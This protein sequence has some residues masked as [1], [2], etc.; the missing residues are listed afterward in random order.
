MNDFVHLHLHSQYSVLDG[1]IRLGD[2]MPR[3]KEHGMTSVAVTDHGNMFGAVDF[4]KK[5]QKYGI[6]PILGVEAYVAEGDRR[7]KTRS[8]FH[9]ILL[10]R[11][12]TGYANLRKLVSFAYLEGFY[13]HPRIDLG[14]LRQHS[15][16]L[17]G[18]SA[19]LGGQIA[20]T[21]LKGRPD[22]AR[23]L[24]RTY[25]DI[26]EPGCFFLEVQPNGIPE[27][28]VVNE[29]YRQIG[30]ELD[31]PLA[32]T[33]DCHYLDQKDAKAH[34]ILMCVQTGKTLDDPTRMRHDTD[35]FWLRPG[36]E[37]WRLMGSEFGDALE[38]TVRIAEMCNVKLDLGN[39]YLPAYRV[40]DDMTIDEFL[41]KKSQDGL[42]ERFNEFADVGKSVD[43]AEYQRRLDDELGVISKMGFA[44]YFL[45]VQDFINWAKDHDIPVGPGRGSGAGSL[46]AYCLRITD[47]DPLPY[48]LLFERFL[49]PERVSMPDF[50]VDFCMNRRDEVIKYV[51][52]KYGRTQVGQIATFGSLKA[53]GVIKDVGRVLGMSFGETDKLSKLVPEVLNITLD[54]AMKQEPRLQEIYDSEP[55]IRELLDIARSLEGLNRSVGMHAAGVVIGDK[56]LWEYCPVFKGANEDLVTQFAKDEVEQAGLVKF[57]FLG[58]KTLTVIQTAVELINRGKKPEDRLDLNKLPLTDPGVYELISRGDTEGVFQLES[59]GFQELLKKLRPDKFEDIV[60]AVALYRPGPLNSGM[61]DDFIDRKHGRQKIVYPHDMLKGILQETYGVIVYQEQVMQIAQVLAGFT[62]GGADLLRRAMGKKKADVMAQQRAVF[63]EGAAKNDVPASQAGEIFDLMEKF[64]EYGFNKSHSAAYALI[65]Y[66]TAYLKAHH[67]VEFMAGL[68]TNDKDASDKVS[69]GIRNAR[70]IGIEVLAPS[71]NLSV[72]DFDVVDGK[73]LF[74]MAGIRGV[75]ENAVEAIVEARKA[76][77]VFKDLFDFCERVDLKRVN[78]KVLEALVKSGAFDFAR[79]PRAR[80]IACLDLAVERAQQAQKDR[81]AGQGSLFDL[82]GGGGGMKASNKLPPELASVDEWPQRQL[83]ANEKDCLGFYVSGHPLD[84]YVDQ[85]EQYTTATIEQLREME[86]YARVTIAGIQTALKV[87][88]FKSGEGKMAIIQFEDHT[89]NVEVLALGDDYNT[90]ESLLCSDEPLLVQ[91]TLRVEKEEDRVNVSVRIGAGRPRRG[92]PEATGP[93]VTLLADVRSSRARAVEIGIAAAAVSP[94]RLSAIGALLREPRHAGQCDAF[95]RITTADG[96]DVKLSVPGVRIAPDDDLQDQI[97]RI[98]SGACTVSVV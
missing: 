47:I 39:V 12:D 35:A 27:Q 81:A 78:K 58:L 70:K 51:M 23:E 6:K 34:E 59:S 32:V 52:E 10:A 72:A 25:R 30:K 96:C 95:L 19:C 20:Q 37:M 40:P 18:L 16:G 97:Q 93:F 94:E 69:K 65:T 76:D 55:R 57:D 33:N 22:H 2:M 74:G 73:I 11:N 38:N 14:L 86:N 45:I 56:P 4:Y 84:R 15:E 88:P 80:M 75:G 68:L 31:I 63:V 42:V 92:E 17:I 36:S 82:L 44:G 41:V 61:L 21:V 77:G 89:G 50:D 64:A 48:G 43:R 87:R 85:I 13:Y 98:F 54:D 49:N 7:D 46:A 71:V 1:A 79:M 26:F 91:G 67:K 5:A 66:H 9:L 8:A 90:Y 28:K 24:A 29:L 83:L 3:L 62:L 60:A 53:R